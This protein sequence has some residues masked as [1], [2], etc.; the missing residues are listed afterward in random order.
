MAKQEL[1]D[2]IISLNSKN[3]PKVQVR[4]VLL[5]V[6]WPVQEVDEAF[7]ESERMTIDWHQPSSANLSGWLAIAAVFILLASVPFWVGTLISPTGHVVAPV[8]PT[9]SPIQS[10]RQSQPIQERQEVVLAPVEVIEEVQTP[11]EVPCTDCEVPALPEPQPTEQVKVDCNTLRGADRDSCFRELA[12]ADNDVDTCQRIAD[13]LILLGCIEALAINNKQPLLC[14]EL[15]DADACFVSY[16]IA[17]GDKS[18]CQKIARTEQRS[19]CL[20]Y[21]KSL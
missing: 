2:Y 5:D 1:V 16:A 7:L 9:Q 15:N 6:G 18:V 12:I 17:T 13:P 11:A 10:N 8:V 21:I 4:Q 3:F 20:S 14:D 19:A